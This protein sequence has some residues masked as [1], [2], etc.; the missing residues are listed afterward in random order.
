MHD[1]FHLG[2]EAQKSQ[3]QDLKEKTE[4]LADDASVLRRL[5]FDDMYDRED[6]ITDATDGTFDWL[7]TNEDVTSNTSTPIQTSDADESKTIR[8]FWE[9]DERGKRQENSA[10]VSDFFE[11]GGG[12]FFLRGKPGSGKSTLMKYLTGGRGKQKVDERLR[13]WAGQKRLI[14]VSMM[15]LLHGAPLQ[16]SLEGFYRT[17]FFELICQCPDFVDILFP[18][19]STGGFGDDFH[20]SSFRLETLKEAWTRLISIRHHSTLRIC[21]FVDGLDELEG[22]SA[23]RLKFARIL[24]DWAE[25]EDIKIMA[26]GRPNAEFN[27]VFQQPHRRVDLQD[28][29][30]VDIRT[31]VT[32][33][34]EDIRHLSDL[35]PESIEVLVNDISDQSEGVILWAVL[36]GKELED[37]IIH[38]TPLRAMKHTIQT[39]PSGIEDLY[40]NM[41]LDLRHNAHQQRMLR[42]IY[43]LLV[44]YDGN[45]GPRAICLFWLED[46]LSDAEFP[47]NQAIEVLPAT[48]LLS[49]VDKVRGHLI[50][51][52]KHFVEIT[53]IRD[54]R[55]HGT[56]RFIHRSAQEFL[57]SKLGPVGSGSTR[58]DRS[59]DLDL[60]LN[61]MFEMSVER[62]YPTEC[63]AVFFTRAFKYP[64]KSRSHKQ[65]SAHQLPDRLM[66]KLREILEARRGLIFGENAD[67]GSVDDYWQRYG[68]HYRYGR[69][70]CVRGR[71]FLFFHLAIKS[72]QVDYVTRILNDRTQ[73]LDEEALCLGLLICVAGWRPSYEL[74]ELLLKH[75][76]NPDCLVEVYRPEKESIP[77]RIPL[78]LVFCSTLAVKVSTTGIDGPK[79]DEFLILERF[80]TLGYGINVK[81]QAAPMGSGCEPDE[82]DLICIDLAQVVRFAHPDNM[83]R[84]LS[85]LEP[86]PTTYFSSVV[87][88]LSHFVLQPHS[89]FRAVPPEAATVAYRRVSDEYLG[90][91]GWEFWFAF[92]GEHEVR[93]DDYYHVPG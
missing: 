46:A 12:V 61:L 15:F 47:Y 27:I 70:E 87:Q 62:R 29:T 88:S 68:F 22:N 58:R 82:T 24:Q 26:S 59:F 85:L 48:E 2:Q 89:P 23:D 20:G 17:L 91:E 4:A 54:V 49:R 72:H 32:K 63:F 11:N 86:P 31:I 75:G 79:A 53:S 92:D 69:V 43:E 14:R 76:A 84:L 21:V 36:V 67:G 3:L 50:Q 83:N 33:R 18:K 28:L 25:S 35:A 19:R 40:N 44:L 30:R 9:E 6:N 41:W 16:R 77:E 7:L 1:S 38:G 74:F 52:M 65:Y 78:W 90:R 8:Q 57:Q 5:Y 73:T 39:L 71:S 51:Y 64:K 10:K 81:F 34:F 80:L 37:D 55:Y 56:C 45:A 13:K 60:R 42:I 93:R 66:E